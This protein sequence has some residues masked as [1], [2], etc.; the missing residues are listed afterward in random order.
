MLSLGDCMSDVFYCYSKKM[1][2]FLRSFDQRYIS[3]KVNIN[4]G[5]RYWT[6]AKSDRLNDLIQLWSSIKNN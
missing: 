6:F 3:T 4:S 2:Y 5:M 1:A